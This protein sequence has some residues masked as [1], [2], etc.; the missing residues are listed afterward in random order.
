MHQGQAGED[1]DAATGTTM[2]GYTAGN[3]MD[4]YDRQKLNQ[5]YEHG[6]SGRSSS[7]HN[8]DNGNIYQVT[9]Q[10]AYPSRTNHAA[11]CRQAE[12]LATIDGK[13]EKTYITACRNSS[14][15]WILQN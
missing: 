13:T 2:T 10:P 4:E 7:W 8:P 11:S 14:G 1:I 12:I 5:V 15:Q 9:P 6:V 3:G